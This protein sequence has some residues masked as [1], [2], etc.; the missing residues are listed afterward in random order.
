M[1]RSL[2][3]TVSK[4]ERKK[5]SI[6]F[7]QRLT[8]CRELVKNCWKSLRNTEGLGGSHLKVGK[9]PCPCS[10]ACSKPSCLQPGHG[11]LLLPHWNL[12]PVPPIGRIY[13]EIGWMTEFRKRD[14]GN[15]ER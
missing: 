4:Q 9:L 13:H 5:H 3:H 6:Y 14:G 2:Y 1:E 12:P 8:Q 7:K 11:S 10:G 15:L